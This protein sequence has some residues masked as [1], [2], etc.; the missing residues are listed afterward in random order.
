[1]FGR[2][3]QAH[4]PINRTKINSD[5]IDG[6]DSMLFESLPHLGDAAL[7]I[8]ECSGHPNELEFVI[9]ASSGRIVPEVQLMNIHQKMNLIVG[10]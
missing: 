9:A 3:S 5:L 7:A 1:L 4:P 2:A 6:E 10:N 8:H